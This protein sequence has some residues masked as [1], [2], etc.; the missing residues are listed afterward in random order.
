ME[1]LNEKPQKR[2]HEPQNYGYC[3]Q[4]SDI[5]GA[6][7]VETC[8]KAESGNGQQEP[9]THTP[10]TQQQER[11]DLKL[12]PTPQKLIGD[13]VLVELLKTKPNSTESGRKMQEFLFGKARGANQ[14]KAA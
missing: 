8:F 14:K 12:K 5:D 2:E 11:Q 3:E 1:Y 4:K 10:Q 13:I 6:S 9:T 7:E